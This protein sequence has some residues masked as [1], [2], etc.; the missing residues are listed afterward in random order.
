[1][2]RPRSATGDVEVLCHDHA[3][4]DGVDGDSDDGCAFSGVAGGVLAVVGVHTD[5]HPSGAGPGND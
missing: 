2:I 4:R 1:M 3:Q 5:G